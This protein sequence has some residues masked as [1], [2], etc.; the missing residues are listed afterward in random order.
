MAMTTIKGVMTA[1]VTPFDGPV[2]DEAEFAAFVAWQ[3]A[4]E[5]DGLVP[6]TTTG[7]GPTLTPAEKE[8]LI[9]ICVEVAAGRVP[10]IAATGT[11]GTDST[12]DLTRRARSAGATAALVVTP[13]YTKPSQEGIYRHFEAIA[14]AVDLPT[15]NIVFLAVPARLEPGVD[16]VVAFEQLLT[17]CG[18]VN[19]GFAI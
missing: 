17:I 1:L 7:E 6:C 15:Q 2:V 11:N 18:V 9:S 5:T 16:H 12:T 3:I 13:Y 10:V 19:F 4:E 14:R 8:R